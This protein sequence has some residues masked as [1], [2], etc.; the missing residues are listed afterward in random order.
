VIVGCFHPWVRSVLNAASNFGRVYALIG[1]LHGFRKFDLLR[2]L[3]L[4]CPRHYTQFKSKI[5]RLYPEKCT[6]G[7]A[8]KI[9]EL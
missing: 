5:E 4:I 3:K 6:K 7:G 8:G 2:D 9:L 1:G